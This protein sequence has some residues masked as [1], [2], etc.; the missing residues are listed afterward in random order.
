MISTSKNANVNYLAKIVKLGKVESHPNADK[1][2]ITSIDFQNIVTGMDA[3]EG[4]LYC[5][6]PL[7]S[8]INI[9]FLAQTN[10]FRHTNLNEVQ[11]DNKPG[12]FDDNG[13]VKAIKL[14]GEKSMGYIVPLS[15]VEK[16]TGVSL[17]EYVGETFDTISK[18]GKDILMV[19]K[20]Q[21]PVKGVQ[22]LKQGKKPVISR[23]IDG[24]VHLHID[25][26]NFRRNAHKIKPEDYIHVSYK[27]HGTSFWVANVLVKKR[28]N[29]FEKVLKKIGINIVDTE[30]DHVYGS[31][32]VVKNESETKKKLHFY[33]YDLWGDIK[34]EIKEFI[35]KGYTF[36]GECVGHTKGGKYIQQK[37][38]YGCSE[39][40]HKIVIYRIT[41]TNKDGVVI[42]L[43]SREIAEI[44]ER[45]GLNYVHT[46]YNGLAKDMYPKLDTEKDWTENFVKNLERDYNEKDC[47]MCE[48]KVPEEGIVIRK[49]SLFQFETYKLKS[50]NFLQFETKML[51]SGEEG[52]DE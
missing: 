14:R 48:N 7:E 49:E 18:K 43:S 40:E 12:F 10:S 19:N 13:R 29:I 3:K 38:D 31:R 44:C 11:D 26:E 30:Y 46:F 50:F 21:L 45:T 35:P 16:Y 2:Q 52:L 47:F 28:L 8:Q 9:G 39:L 51:D 5:F 4:D 27:I 23:L 37:F 20:Y 22:G 15:E 33:E 6:F 36:Y 32:R 34:E 24:Q 17:E 1:L 25:T 42:D 41:L